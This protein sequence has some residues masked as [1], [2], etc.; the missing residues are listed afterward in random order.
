MSEEKGNY[1]QCEKCG[2][3]VNTELEGLEN[4]FN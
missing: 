4:S 1:I 2:E 3:T